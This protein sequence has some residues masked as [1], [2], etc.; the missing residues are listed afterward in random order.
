[1]NL[2]GTKLEC[3]TCGGQVVVT[4]GGD[5]EIHCH[6]APMRVIAGA[7]DASSQAA[8]AQRSTAEEPDDVEYF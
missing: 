4:T 5:G 2:L 7:G 8:R 3:E 6:G 1:M